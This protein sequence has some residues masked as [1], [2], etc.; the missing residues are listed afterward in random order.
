[1]FGSVDVGC[2]GVV[3]DVVVLGQGYGVGCGKYVTSEI[4]LP[5]VAI[6]S[7]PRVMTT[8]LSLRPFVAR[9]ASFIA[10]VVVV[11][12]EFGEHK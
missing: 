5:L 2:D 8:W 7:L 1:M 12:D 9:S 3:V 6:I 11:A 10:L 4:L